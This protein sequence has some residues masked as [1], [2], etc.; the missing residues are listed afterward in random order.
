MSL[1][2]EIRE[3]LREHITWAQSEYQEQADKNRQPHPQYRIG[4]LV[5]V[6]ARHFAGERPSKSLGSKNMGPWKIT[7][8][9]ND[10]AYEVELPEDLKRANVT[11]IFHPWKLHLAPRN[12]FPGQYPDPQPP[13]ILTNDE[14]DE[15]EEW[16]IAEKQRDMEFN[17][18]LDLWGTG[19]TGTQIHHGSLGQTLRMLLTRLWTSIRNTQRSPNLQNFSWK[20]DVD[21]F[22]Y[23]SR[24]FSKRG[25]VSGPLP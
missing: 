7:R 1:T 6:D 14:E 3:Y 5:Y 20:E 8:V 2:E 15:H 10:K 22:F 19:T 13:V 18:R 23:G 16:W 9:I 17:T 11:P 25:V 21:N 4:D 12:P 24:I